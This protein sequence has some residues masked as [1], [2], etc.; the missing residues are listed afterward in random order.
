MAGAGAGGGAGVGAGAAAAGG[1][2][3][4]GVA[5]I[6]AMAEAFL[7]RYFVLFDSN[8]AQLCGVYRAASRLTFEKDMYQGVTAILAKLAAIPTDVV[9]SIKSM[10]IQPSGCGGGILAF[11]CGDI[12]PKGA[13]A[14]LK[15]ARIFHLVPPDRS[16]P[17]WWIHND[18]FRLN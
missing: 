1:G 2:G 13:P 12:K 11:C 8:R 5:N 4:G 14:P 7:R 10:D 17:T 6:G 16:N 3:G 9:H 15:F 18:I